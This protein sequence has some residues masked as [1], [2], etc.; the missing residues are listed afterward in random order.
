MDVVSTIIRTEIDIYDKA[1][2]LEHHK[3]KMEEAENRREQ[4]TGSDSSD[5][6]GSDSKEDSVSPRIIHGSLH[7]PCS[8][9]QLETVNSNDPTFRNARLKLS[10]ALSKRLNVAQVVLRGSD[11]VS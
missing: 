8:L 1:M 7:P 3:N 10:K 4:S 5:S 2:D 9:S 6:S 11:I